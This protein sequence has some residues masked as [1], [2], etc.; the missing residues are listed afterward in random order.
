MSTEKQ[1]SIIGVL[2]TVFLILTIGIVLYASQPIV[3]TLLDPI[4]PSATPPANFTSVETIQ[5]RNL[6]LN[7]TANATGMLPHQGP[8]SFIMTLLI[9][10]TNIGSENVSNFQAIK[11]SVYNSDSELFYT[12]S[13]HPDW[14]ATIPAGETMTLT[15]RNEPTLV[16]STI[17]PWE[18][19]GRVLVSFD[20]NETAVITTPRIFG[21]FAVE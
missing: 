1:R 10:I 16:Y 14:N 5:V 7:A 19:Y 4:P 13:I 20:I 9:N 3:P 17:R 8:V 6:V 2:F 21:V 12:F 15:Y 18:I 11:M